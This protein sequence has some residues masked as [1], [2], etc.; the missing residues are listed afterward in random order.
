MKTSIVLIIILI[1]KFPS[2]FA[3]EALDVQG[4]KIIKDGRIYFIL[5]DK[6]IEYFTYDDTPDGRKNSKDLVTFSL[7]DD[8]FC[9][10]YLKWINPLRYRI[11]WKD[12]LYNDERDKTINDFIALLTAQ[13]GSSVTS[14]NKTESKSMIENSNTAKL[15]TNETMLCGF[16]KGFNNTDLTT[17]YL[18]LR[19]SQNRLTEAERIKLNKFTPI[20]IELDV[21]N[22]ED[23]NAAVNKIFTDLFNIKEPNNISNI[24]DDKKI[25]LEKFKTHFK[26]IEDL[27]KQVANQLS[28][29]NIEDALLNSYT[30]SVIL[31][32]IDQ[33]ITN[34][35]LNKKLTKNLN[36]IID[37]IEASIDDESENLLT[38][39]YYRIK[40]VSFEDGKKIE[41]SLVVSEYEFNNDTKEFLKK[42]D[43]I[44][45]T[46][47][48]RKYDFIAISVSTGIFYSSTTLKGFGVAQN[49]SGE[50][51][52]S[53]DDITKSNPVTAVFLNFNFGIG[54]RYFA[55]LAQI[56]IDPTKKR[57]FLLLGGG[58]SIPSAKIAFSSGPIWT[59]SQT[60]DKL[61]VG[62]TIS[63]TTELENDIQYKFDMTP[64][65]WYIGIQYNF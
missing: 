58:F 8:N 30:K 33:T 60:L 52:V 14:L 49:S 16:E 5:K 25:E 11:T 29:I 32:F 39:G 6:N 57:P 22:S 18:Q 46:L 41:C 2:L 61:S 38:K 3:Q 37:I 64:K 9:N 31:K 13:F 51:I 20:I 7:K 53:G 26:K 63:S 1:L 55:P 42:A 24:V 43:I 21:K 4:K 59:W 62:Q 47:V 35:N 15:K 65:G 12:S 34:L 36:P 40:S 48:F 45:K 56:G 10:I 19:T 50:F 44:K 28:E 54:S 23:I 17:L 27:Q